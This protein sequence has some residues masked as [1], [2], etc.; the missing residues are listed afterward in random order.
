MPVSTQFV[1]TYKPLIM[2]DQ[3]TLRE[4]RR[5]ILPQLSR[6]VA[7]EGE[8]NDRNGKNFIYRM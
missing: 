8:V 1:I 5:E 6:M 3:Q 2:T 7:M 4:R